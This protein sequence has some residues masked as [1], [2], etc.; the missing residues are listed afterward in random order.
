MFSYYAACSED[1]ADWVQVMAV[2]SRTSPACIVN[3]WTASRVAF[4]SDFIHLYSVQLF[5]ADPPGDARVI[6]SSSRGLQC[7]VIMYC[8][9]AFYNCATCLTFGG[10][11]A[12]L[13]HPNFTGPDGTQ[14]SHV[15]AG[16]CTVS[17]QSL[18]DNCKITASKVPRAGDMDFSVPPSACCGVGYE[19]AQKT[20]G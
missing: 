10:K 16:K 12:D 4:L 20:S 8:G 17:T 11:W 9:M 2:S 7:K 14:Y 6:A 19:I 18:E 13:A 3:L 15:Y 5:Y 1:K